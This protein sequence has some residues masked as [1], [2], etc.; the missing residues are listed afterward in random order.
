MD[1][2]LLKTLGLKWS[3]FI[4][5]DI[6]PTDKQV[7]FMMLPHREAMYGG[8][9]GSGK[10]IVLSVLALQYAD[11]PKYSGIIFRRT[12]TEANLSGSI[13]D[14]L[15][16]WLSPRMGKGGDVKFDANYNT[17]YFLE[18][19]SQLTIAY[20]RSELDHERYKGS[21]YHF[22]VEK[23]TPVLMDTGVY[24]CI[25]DICIGDMV[26]T[27]EGPKPV[28]YVSEPRTKFCVK[29]NN[30]IQG[31]D[32]KFYS[33]R[34]WISYETFLSTLLN[35]PHNTFL[36]TE[37]KF[38][39][40]L[41]THEN[42]LKNS[43]QPYELIG[44][45][46]FDSSYLQDFYAWL[47]DDRNDYGAFGDLHQVISQLPKWS[48]PLE[49][50]SPAYQSKLQD[51]ENE[52]VPLELEF[53]NSQTYY[54]ALSHLYDEHA[55]YLYHSNTSLC[56]LLPLND[57]DIHNHILKKQD[58]LDT[59][60][61]HNHSLLNNYVHPYTN[62]HRSLAYTTV[63]S[64]EKIEPFGFSEVIDIR[65][66]DASHYI[67]SGKFINSNCGFD[68]LTD[69]A[70]DQFRFLNRSLRRSLQGPEAKIPLRIR[71]ATNPGGLG[72]CVPYGEVLTPTGWKDIKDFKVGDAV[73]EVD[74]KGKLVPSKV[75]QLHK[76][77]APKLLTTN[78]RGF[79][80]SCTPE[81][82]VAFVSKRKNGYSDYSLREFENL[83]GQACI[84]RTVSWK[85]KNPKYFEVPKVITRR[86]K[87]NQPKKLKW[88]DYCK[89]L[90]WYLSEGCTIDRDKAF[91]I[92]QVKKPQ[93]K[94]IS[95]LL[96]TC[97]FTFSTNTVGFT[98][99]CPDWY[100]HFKQ[101][102][103]NLDKFIPSEVL[104][105][106]TKNLTHLFNALMGGDGHWYGETSGQ[107]YT[108]SKQLSDDVL[109]LAVKLGYIADCWHRDRTGDATVKSRKRCYQISF[110]KTLSGGTELLTGNHVYDVATS[111][112]RKSNI[113]ESDFNKTVY[114]LGVPKY[115]TFVIRQRGY[116]W[117]SGNCWVKNRYK[118]NKCEGK[119][120]HESDFKFRGHDPER[121]FIQATLKDNPYIDQ[122]S[123]TLALN[124]MGEIDRMRM[125]EGNWDVSAGARFK[126]EYFIN[127]WRINGA[128][129]YCEQIERTW[130]R[131][132]C[133]IFITMDVA[134]ST[135]TG[136]ANTNFRVQQERSYTVMSVWAKTPDNY[137]LWLDQIRI[138]AEIPDILAMLTKVC[139]MHKPSKVIVDAQGIGKGVAQMASFNGIPVDEVP[140]TSDK[141]QNSATAQTRAK[142]GKVILPESAPWLDILTGELFTWTGHP[143]ETDDQIDAL[144]NAALYVQSQ[145]MYGEREY[146]TQPLSLPTAMGEG[147]HNGYASDNYY[148]ST[149]SFSGEE[150]PN[151]L[152]N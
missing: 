90:G 115:H 7:A 137:L 79:H 40:L 93:R 76:Y 15:L 119:C 81:H 134:A 4:P 18:Y 148:P 116:V 21:S 110:K 53:S 97:G 25:K 111:T 127:R 72:H 19:E 107:Y 114:C 5:E 46:S 10:S 47:K 103:K 82:K 49:H 75:K 67:T 95:K 35:V 142:R 68:E 87:H 50:F 113:V 77:K 56:C 71:S 131:A 54:D 37:K 59:S 45:Q 63:S 34:K 73:Y 85:G 96:E 143:H 51:D 102:G 83:P 29:V 60:L 99:Y 48:V 126:A 41:Q 149:P 8:A 129:F 132:G 74:P 57:V 104:N 122:S 44:Q 108:V 13:M 24:K 12:L 58:V 27:L 32:H 89:L 106:T 11:I 39:S 64:Q 98:V 112:K 36:Q 88:S 150:M 80:L 140:T 141:I 133:E 139:K 20:L 138:Q 70:E 118:I 55:Q 78:L 84:L 31:W 86:R 22:C 136:V 124:E 43:L 61:K 128:Y 144:S 146:E 121:P 151:F 152:G 69:F 1:K 105:S 23:N 145:V 9:A 33:N 65:V 30:Q 123:Y 26:Q 28:T 14:I 3:H 66:A 6:S 125:K 52:Y 94:K 130:H 109:T 92:S 91:V 120:E 62:Q 17:F 117:V 147:W 38:Q 101:F 100:N 2:E 135:R 42:Q 16:T